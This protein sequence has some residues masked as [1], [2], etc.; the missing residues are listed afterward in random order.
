MI[1][2]FDR[3]IGVSSGVEQTVFLISTG[4]LVVVAFGRFTSRGSEHGHFDLTS[5]KIPQSRLP[6]CVDQIRR[7]LQV[8]SRKRD[9]SGGEISE[10]I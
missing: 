7:L 2:A 10:Y 5:L 9:S 8:R 6:S 4:L 3:Q 1:T